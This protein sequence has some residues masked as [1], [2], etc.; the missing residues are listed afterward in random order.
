MR[1][2]RSLDPNIPLKRREL[3]KYALD[4]NLSLPEGARGNCGFSLE[5]RSG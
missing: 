1:R 5:H 3:V 2:S 4:S